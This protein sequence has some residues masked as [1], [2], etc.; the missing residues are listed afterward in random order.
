MNS[1]AVKVLTIFLLVGANNLYANEFNN[2]RGYNGS[3]ATSMMSGMVDFMAWFLGQGNRGNDYSN[4]LNNLSQGVPTPPWVGEHMLDG[5][6]VAQT[7]EHW[8]IRG[9]QFVLF[10]NSKQKTSGEFIVEG[11]FI[12]V[13]LPRGEIE[14]E[15]RQ[16]NGILMLR[17]VNGHTMVLRR[18]KAGSWEW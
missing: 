8:Y 1:V 18:I 14:F 15:F 17:D 3:V 7:G 2:S 5:T 16:R 9:N 13:R 10:D 4:G 6:W 11:D 12:I